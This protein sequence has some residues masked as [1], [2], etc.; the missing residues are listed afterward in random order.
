MKKYL[1]ALMMTAAV[2]A[3]LTSCSEKLK[4][5]SG[6]VANVE[7]SNLGDTLKSMKLF[8]GEDTLVFALKEA[9]YNNGVMLAKDSVDV[10]YLKGHHTDTLRAMLVYVKPQPAHVIEVKVDTTKKLLTR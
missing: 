5:A 10:Y 9:Q 2:C 3:T 7:S 4:K 6:V 8:D 1:I